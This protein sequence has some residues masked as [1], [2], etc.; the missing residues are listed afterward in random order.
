[1]TAQEI[2]PAIGFIGLGNMGLPIAQKLLAYPGGLVVCDPR[3]DAVTDIVASGAVRCATPAAIAATAS[4]ICVTVLNDEQ[5]RAVI[6]G[7][8]GILETASAGTIIAIHSTISPE[9]AIELATLC[10][11]QQ[12]DLV[13]APVSGGAPGARN[14]TLAVMIGGSD[15]A[16]AKLN[17]P[18]QLFA[19][20][21]VYTGPVG[22]GTKM[23]LARNLLHFVAFAATTEANRLASDANLDLVTLGKIVRHT[24]AITGG[25]G[26][27]MLRDNVNQLAADSPWFNIFTHVRNLGEKDLSLALALG[28]TQNTP[29][30]FAQLAFQQLG[31]GLGVGIS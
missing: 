17:E 25:A 19:S 8:D 6:S 21:V 27:I 3:D 1:M 30:P 2:K 9:T 31:T 5:V 28:A 16:F 11:A 23:K 22:S 18:F 26:A 7:P 4:I 13:D 14:G 20:L 10:A 15:T 24:D 12:V 29:L